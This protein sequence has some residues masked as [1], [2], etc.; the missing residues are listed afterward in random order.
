MGYLYFRNFTNFN[1][2]NSLAIIHFDASLGIPSDYEKSCV[3]CPGEPG[4]GKSSNAELM[5]NIVV[6][7]KH[8]AENYT[9]SKKETDEMEANKLISQLYVINE[10]KECNDSFFKSTADSTKSNS[11][12]RKYQGSQKYEA[13]FK[14]MIINNKPLY[15]SNYDKG[16][17]N[18]FTIIYTDHFFEENLPFS[19]S[20]Y[21]HIKLKK[22]PMERAYYESVITPV[23]LF[24]SHIL[25]YKRNKKDGYISYKNI[26][27]NDAIHNH[28]LMCLDINNSTIN[29]LIYVLRVR[30]QHGSK[31]IDESQIDKM[32][33]L[34][35][36]YVEVLLHDSMKSKRNSVNRINQLCAD[37][38]KRYKKYHRAEERMF[39]NL[40][41]ALSKNDFNLIIPTFKC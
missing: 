18:R 27:K 23:R 33:E 20:V 38:K 39:I 5:E 4:S 32:I 8:D 3:Y 37:F 16:V 29:A 14:L 17:R 34:A 24:L 31:P 36:P 15:I 2:V 40:D 13:N 26:L 35:V 28:N 12:C 30:V 7:H 19:G 1:Y 25:M 9:L 22:F 21:S 11:V 10:M 6:V 41:M